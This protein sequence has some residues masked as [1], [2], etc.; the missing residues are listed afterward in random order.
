M[1]E[2]YLGIL[3]PRTCSL[4]MEAPEKQMQTVVDVAFAACPAKPTTTRRKSIKP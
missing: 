4:S 3:R 1:T 2:N